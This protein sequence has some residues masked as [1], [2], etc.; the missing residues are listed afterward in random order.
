[1]NLQTN[2]RVII[3]NSVTKDA[4]SGLDGLLNGAHGRI[5]FVVEYDD[6][7]TLYGVAFDTPIEHNGHTFNEYSFVAGN[8]SS[9]DLNDICC[10]RDEI[11]RLGLGTPVSES[12]ISDLEN[13][14]AMIDKLGFEWSDNGECY[15]AEGKDGTYFIQDGS[16]HL[17]QYLSNK[18]VEAGLSPAN[19]THGAFHDCV[20]EACRLE[21]L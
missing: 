13:Q 16:H 10:M 17:L 12:L 1:M 11:K 9:L 15:A 21:G 20:T 7:A 18:E 2:Q 5:V 14:I 3:S 4:D 6:S 8:L 19:L